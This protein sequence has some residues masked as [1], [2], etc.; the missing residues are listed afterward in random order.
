MSNIPK[1]PKT[2][3]VLLVE[4]DPADAFLIRTMLEEAKGTSFAANVAGSLRE[5]LAWLSA[6]PCQAVVLD[7]S[8]PDSRGLATFHQLRQHHPALPVVVLTGLDD[9]SLAL[10]AV[11]EGAQ[12]FLVKGQVRERRLTQALHHAMGRQRRLL[13][14]E[15]AL[16][17]SQE[18]ERVA[19]EIAKQLL[20]TTAPEMTGFDLFGHSIPRG[21]SGGDLLDW[22]QVA[23]GCWR[24]AIGDVTGHGLGPSLLMATTRAYLRAYASM[25]VSIEETLA[26]TNEALLE[27]L[28]DSRNVTLFLAELDPATRRLT[29]A[30]A[31]HVP[32]LLVDRHGAVRERL[33]STGLP[34]GVLENATYPGED[35]LALEPGDVLILPTDGVLDAV[36]V[37]QGHFGV[38]G[39]IQSVRRRLAGVSQALTA[40][41]VVESI[42]TGVA[43]WTQGKEPADDCTLVAL[44]SLGT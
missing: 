6:N 32:G 26:K 4:D 37:G 22:Y 7:L 29:Y 11:S 13:R 17:H 1:A 31:G 14:V 38:D 16:E 19:R 40:E 20:P 43:T 3:H 18:E 25:G 39:V 35:P 5:A 21:A 9:E 28:G 34:L 33:F 27:D 2:L 36:R 42:F 8:L 10:Q 15:K 12:D 44:R 23:S 24:I 30:S 41:G